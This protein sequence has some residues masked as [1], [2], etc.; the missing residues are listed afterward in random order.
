MTDVLQSTGDM[1]EEMKEKLESAR[2]SQD[3][4]ESLYGTYFLGND[5]FAFH[6]REMQEVVNY[7]AKVDRL[8]LMPAY[9]EGVFNLRDRILPLVSLRRVLEI[10]V[11]S[12]PEKSK[13]YVGII[14]ISGQLVGV[15]LDRTGD[16]LSLA[17]DDIAKVERKNAV[18]IVSG[19]ANL[20]EGKRV[21]RVV[22]A[23]KILEM[24]DMP[25]LS[26]K[27]EDQ[28]RENQSGVTVGG[29]GI[30]Q[31]A[32]SFTSESSEFAVPVSE[33]LEVLENPR[34]E[35][36]HIAY[37]NCLG[38]LN[39]RGTMI[40]VID[41]R[42][43]MGS[44]TQTDLDT[45][46]VLV[47]IAGHK[48][49]GFLVDTVT[50]VFDFSQSQVMPIPA[51]KEN[52]RKGCL[53]GVLS[54]GGDR[55]VFLID[56]GALCGEEDIVE[57]I[58][59]CSV[60]DALGSEGKRSGDASSLARNDSFEG[61][62]ELKVYV[63]FRLGKTLAAEITEV[64][65]IIAFPSELMEPPG[66]EGYLRG[67]LN[68]RGAII[69]IVDMRRYYGMSDYKNLKEASVLIVAYEDSRYGLIVDSVE[70]SVDVYKSQTT[71]I[72]KVVNDSSDAEYKQDISR[73][74]EY[75]NMEGRTTTLMVYS[76]ESFLKNLVNEPVAAG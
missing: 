26:Q 25:V 28:S 22:D 57:A 49:C 1:L 9:V 41:F 24:D 18:S 45:G 14:K 48:Y 19:L 50:D 64:D 6:I 69:P 76:V 7:P 8:P 46:M 58:E 67:M 4:V 33:I 34:L 39:L 75:T 63:T 43:T 2:G 20:D 66:Y 59:A 27:I 65:E 72:P 15:E 73:V 74:L 54:V 55:N 30:G 38:I 51:L 21:V 3:G 42:S 62:D 61:Q 11:D 32:I 44:D 5:E 23:S 40:S 52:R 70:D 56:S 35:D 10:S 47:V 29:I 17:E 12:E 60:P 53:K 68:L 37:D 71:V 16:V 13:M 36:T 31:T